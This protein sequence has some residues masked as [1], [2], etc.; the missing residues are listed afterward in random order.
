VKII[1]NHSRRN[2]TGNIYPQKS[3]LNDDIQCLVNGRNKLNN[4]LRKLLNYK[5][6][7]QVFM[8]NFVVN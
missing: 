3:N 8:A 5:T 2:Y 1:K 7:L 6:A 4:R